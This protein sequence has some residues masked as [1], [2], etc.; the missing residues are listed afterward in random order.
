MI[1]ILSLSF[2][3]TISQFLTVPHTEAMKD[4]LR[5]TE[6]AFKSVDHLGINFQVECHLKVLPHHPLYPSQ[7]PGQPN[8]WKFYLDASPCN[9]PL[10]T[11]FPT[12]DRAKVSLIFLKENRQQQS[13]ECVVLE[14]GIENG[15]L[16]F[17]TFSYNQSLASQG[18]HTCILVVCRNFVWFKRNNSQKDTDSDSD[19]ASGFY[20]QSRSNAAQPLRYVHSERPGTF[21]L[22]ANHDD[23][24]LM[25]YEEGKVQAKCRLVRERTSRQ[26]TISDVS[27]SGSTGSPWTAKL[28]LDDSALAWGGPW[29][30]GE[31]STLTLAGNDLCLY[32]SRAFPLCS[33]VTPWKVRRSS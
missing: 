2:L 6:H 3:L 10:P 12:R 14:S 20:F 7:T 16:F 8:R 22:Q 28:T 33:F 9:R 31:G 23:E 26:A 29:A 15:R 21:Y 24:T 1:L 19:I 4:H 17:V 13:E 30:V 27:G 32:V 11:M 18:L 5:L 25:F